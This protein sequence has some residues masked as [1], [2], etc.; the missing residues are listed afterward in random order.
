MDLSVIIVNYNTA[1]D[2]RD[3][4]RSILAAAMR[5]DLEVLVVD[6][7]SPDASVDMVRREF[8]DVRLICNDR[9]LGFPAAN[10]QAL[11]LAAG[12][13]FCS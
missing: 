10:N 8:P 12:D 11:P 13:I 5:L 7:A 4:L 6:N 9:N 2:L 3:C 1:G